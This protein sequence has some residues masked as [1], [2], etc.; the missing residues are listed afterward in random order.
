MKLELEEVRQRAWDLAGRAPLKGRKLVPCPFKNRHT[1]GDRTP[2]CSIQIWQDRVVASCFGCGA[3]NKEILGALGYDVGFVPYTPFR[4]PV[5]KKETNNKPT[6]LELRRELVQHQQAINGDPTIMIKVAMHHG[7]LLQKHNLSKVIGF[8][9]EASAVVYPLYD[10]VGNL[11][12]IQYRS[13][14]TGRKWGYTGTT[15]PTYCHYSAVGEELM[16]DGFPV[17]VLVEGPGDAITLAFNGIKTYFTCGCKRMAKGLEQIYNDWDRD[18][19]LITICDSG[20]PGTQAYEECLT[21]RTE[22]ARVNKGNVKVVQALDKDMRDIAVEA[23][24]PIR[25]IVSQILDAD[26]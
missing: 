22:N 26:I 20:D 19:K 8:D 24:T 1:N 15:I 14:A 9:V 23:T 7:L 5:K 6:Q 17:E 16:H 12:S 18:K 21:V 11:T 10:I 25:K 13:L 3:K 4:N 2:S